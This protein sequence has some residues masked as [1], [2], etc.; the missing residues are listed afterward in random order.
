ME[1][2]VKKT[3]KQQNTLDDSIWKMQVNDVII[4]SSLQSSER[5][6]FLSEATKIKLRGRIPG[7][8][9]ASLHFSWQQKLMRKL[10]TGTIIINLI[11]NIQDKGNKENKFYH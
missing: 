5:A 9:V 3:K 6:H 1:V 2:D 11:N 8:F 10:L 7:S 4:R